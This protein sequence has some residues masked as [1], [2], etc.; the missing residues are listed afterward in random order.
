MNRFNAI[1]LVAGLAGSLSFATSLGAHPRRAVTITTGSVDRVYYPIAG[2][3]SRITSEACDLSIR[4][5]VRSSAG[6]VANAQLIRSGG[7]AFALLQNDIAYYAFNGVEL[8][9]F[10]G[11]PVRNMA[12]AFSM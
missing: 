2:A 9:V 8:G 5:T 12:G 10:M 1:V 4:A 11:K 3:M 6:S 7:A